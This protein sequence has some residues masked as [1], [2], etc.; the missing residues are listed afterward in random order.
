MSLTLD[1][2][3]RAVAR[4][5]ELKATP[6]L[7]RIHGTT[8]LT[9][10]KQ[11]RFPRGKRKRIQKKFKKL[12]TREV[13][14]NQMYLLPDG[15]LVCHVFWEKLVREQIDQFYRTNEG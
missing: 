2:L 13:P 7:R 10:T 9:E 12:Y 8:Y 6:Q 1:E 3:Q 14:S 5:D 15:T 4:L 11:V